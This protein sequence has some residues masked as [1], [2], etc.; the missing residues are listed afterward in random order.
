MSKRLI[1]GPAVRAIREAKAQQPATDEHDPKDFV[2][3]RFA[4]KC[5]MSHG[6]L[7]NIEK[8][9]KNATP[10]ETIQRIADQLG[11]PIEAISY[12]V[13]STEALAA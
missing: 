10:V 6:H 5:L 12:E 7:C 4:I 1:L 13:A 2:G 11:V 9:R 3:A 8:G